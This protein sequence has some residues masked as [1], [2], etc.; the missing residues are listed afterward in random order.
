MPPDVLPFTSASLE[1][2]QLHQVGQTPTCPAAGGDATFTA[3]KDAVQI[4]HLQNAVPGL[5]RYLVDP[6]WK[7]MKVE[8]ES[9]IMNDPAA[10]DMRVTEDPMPSGVP[11][12]VS[13][14]PTHHVP[15][16]DVVGVPVVHDLH[17]PEMNGLNPN[18]NIALGQVHK[19]HPR[20]QL[21]HVRHGGTATPM[22]HAVSIGIEHGFIPK[23]AFLRG[24]VKFCKDLWG[25]GN[26]IDA[27]GYDLK[28]SCL[29]DH[30]GISLM[31]FLCDGSGTRQEAL[32][33]RLPTPSINSPADE[34][35]PDI[36]QHSHVVVHTAPAMKHFAHR[37][38][39]RQV[40]LQDPSADRSVKAIVSSRTPWGSNRDG[41]FRCGKSLAAGE[42]R[43]QYNAHTNSL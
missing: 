20:F 11:G 30:L 25:N 14:D 34:L 22:V 13:P 27:L 3:S 28:N 37:D 35:R 38:G 15:P 43:Q 5:A 9:P 29:E 12:G 8:H 41:P 40:I 39:P 36:C 18:V 24:Q 26:L 23:M 4:A 19:P 31:Q 6:Q 42:S 32:Q 10:G 7:R 2:V 33:T 17:L 16:V 21:T 1:V